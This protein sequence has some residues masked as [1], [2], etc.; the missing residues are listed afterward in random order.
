VVGKPE[1]TTPFG[2]SKRKLEGNINMGLGEIRWKGA[3]SSGS[4]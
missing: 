1:G 4:R 2:R 3:D